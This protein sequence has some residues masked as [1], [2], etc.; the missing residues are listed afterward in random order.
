MNFS[1][2]VDIIGRATTRGSRAPIVDLMTLLH[3]TAAQDT[4]HI[5][6]KGVA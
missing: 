2:L 3:T 4:L 5:N 1:Q 6:A